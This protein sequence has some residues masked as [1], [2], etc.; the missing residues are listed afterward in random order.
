MRIVCNQKPIMFLASIAVVSR[1]CVLDTQVRLLL[2]TGIVRCTERERENG[3]SGASLLHACV[4]KF[5]GEIE[6]EAYLK[7]LA[8]DRLSIA[9]VRLLRSLARSLVVFPPLS[10]WS[11]FAFYAGRLV[12]VSSAAVWGSG[13]IIMGKRNCL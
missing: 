4:T 6:D 3:Q 11:T 9:A 7:T 12:Q 10:G 5:T 13:L 1:C 8:A 2:G